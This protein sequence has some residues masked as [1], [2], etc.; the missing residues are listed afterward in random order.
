MSDRKV[1][2]RKDGSKII[3]GINAKGEKFRKVMSAPGKRTKVSKSTT[4]AQGVTTKTNAAGTKTTTKTNDAGSTYA[5]RTKKDGSSMHSLTKKDGSK[6]VARRNAKG[7]VSTKD[8]NKRG[9]VTEITRTKKDGEKVTHGKRSVAVKAA[10]IA[11]SGT[12][13]LAKRMQSLKAK[14][15]AARKAGDTEKVAEL[16]KKTQATRKNIKSNIRHRR[17]NISN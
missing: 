14:K 10:N 4:N 5:S 16:R 17:S 6:Q 1:R 13:K 11:K 12:S 7:A 15:K 9:R 3:T 2:V 8:T